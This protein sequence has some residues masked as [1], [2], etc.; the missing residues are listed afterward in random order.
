MQHTT[1]KLPAFPQ[2]AGRAGV[3][4]NAP[5]VMLAITASQRA[6]GSLNIQ[7]F[8]SL[9]KKKKNPLRCATAIRLDLELNTQPSACT[10][11]L[12]GL[13]TEPLAEQSA[14]QGQQPGLLSFPLS[15]LT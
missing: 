11:I 10:G 15:A 6:A 14:A 7:T 4:S 12:P 8:S 9:S 2:P 1:Q 5:N 3:V 13:L